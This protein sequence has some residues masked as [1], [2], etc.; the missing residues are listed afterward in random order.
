[1]SS[2]FGVPH[3]VVGLVDVPAEGAWSADA[4]VRDYLGRASRVE[5]E[6]TVIAGRLA[7]FGGGVGTS[8]AADLTQLRVDLDQLLE[9]FLLESAE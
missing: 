4:L 7:A 6:R 2:M 9:N 3:Q 8:L 5:R 1:M